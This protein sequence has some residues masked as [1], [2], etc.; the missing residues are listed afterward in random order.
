MLRRAILDMTEFGCASCVYAIE[1]MG[2]KL[3]GVQN[4]EADLGRKEI[5]VVYDDPAAVESIQDYIRKIGHEA[6]LREDTCA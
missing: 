3:P 5:R 4:I 6:P 2:R 1:K